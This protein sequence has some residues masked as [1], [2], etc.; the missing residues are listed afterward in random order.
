MSSLL[1]LEKVRRKTGGDEP[2]SDQKDLPVTGTKGVVVQG[3]G[4]LWEC[5]CSLNKQKSLGCDVTVGQHH[6]ELGVSI[7][8]SC[9][10]CCYGSQVSQWKKL[11]EGVR[12]LC[13]GFLS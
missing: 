11:E 9:L 7:G 6:Q 1:N 12:A 4:P 5:L 3:D 8:S 10:A 2:C 13:V